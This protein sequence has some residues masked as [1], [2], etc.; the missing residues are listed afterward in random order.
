[1]YELVHFLTK[2]F[3]VFVVHGN[4]YLV[5]YLSIGVCFHLSTDEDIRTFSYIDIHTHTHIP[6]YFAISKAQT[7]GETNANTF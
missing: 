6:Y 3:F 7:L 4:I 1:M 2:D 5:S